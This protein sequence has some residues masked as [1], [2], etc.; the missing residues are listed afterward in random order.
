MPHRVSVPCRTLTAGE[1]SLSSCRRSRR[2]PYRRLSGGR[3][4]GSGRYPLSPDTDEGRAPTEPS[5]PAFDR[6]TATQ[7]GLPER[8]RPN[9]IHVTCRPRRRARAC[10][11]S[12]LARPRSLP[13]FAEWPLSQ[14]Q[15]VA[16]ELLWVAV[17]R[18][19]R[20]GKGDSPLSFPCVT[21]IVLQ[22]FWNEP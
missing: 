15:V 16:S 7:R 1:S 20:R 6:L 9:R 2:R 19:D 8:D 17:K 5:R 13:E 14:R 10:N 3:G 12:L 22:F 11:E 21:S 4:S 18:I